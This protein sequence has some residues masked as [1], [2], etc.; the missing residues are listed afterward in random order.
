MNLRSLLL[1]LKTLTELSIYNFRQRPFILRIVFQVH[2]LFF[3]CLLVFLTIRLAQSTHPKTVEHYS[4]VNSVKLS[5]LK[6][7][8]LIN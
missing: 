8:L 4:S 7:K 5:L 2:G 6:K 1:P 3:G